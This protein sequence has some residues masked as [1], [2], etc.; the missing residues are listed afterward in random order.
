[1]ARC[2]KCVKIQQQ[3]AQ[4]ALALLQ[5]ARERAAK[6]L[7][8]ALALMAELEKKARELAHHRQQER[9]E[10]LAS[11]AAAVEAGQ[12]KR[13]QLEE[14]AR[15][16]AFEEEQ[17]R[18]ADAEEAAARK[19]LFEAQQLF[20]EENEKRV[21]HEVYARKEMIRLQKKAAAAAWERAQA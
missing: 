14:D 6:Q 3:K 19:L 21:A 1:M 12:A 10:E 4:E 11:L 17:K 15:R 9:Q 20:A 2:P 16:R 18:I 5:A 13:R 7:A 8:D